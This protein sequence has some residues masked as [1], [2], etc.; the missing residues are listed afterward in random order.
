[1][2]SENPTVLS[3]QDLLAN[4]RT[5]TGINIIDRDALEPLEVLVDSL[6]TEAELHELGPKRMQEKLL[7]ILTNRLR[8]LRDFEAHPEIADEEIVEPIFFV[9][10][11]RTGSTK[12]QRML[13]SSEDFNWLPLWKTLNSASYTGKPNENVAPRIADSDHFARDFH[14]GSPDVAVTHEFGS[15]LAEEETF[16][17]IQSL[18]CSGFHAFAN[19]PAYQVWLASQDAER[20]YRYLRDALKYLQ[21]QGLADPS[22]RWLLKSPHHCGREDILSKVFPGASTVFTHRPPTQFLPS[23]CSLLAAHIASH[24]DNTT[25][26]GHAVVTGYAGDLERHVA[27]RKA[28]P[29][30]PVLDIHYKDATGN[31]RETIERFYKFVGLPLTSNALQRMLSWDGNNPIHKHGVHKYTLADFDLSEA[32]IIRQAPNYQAFYREAFGD[33]EGW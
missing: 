32:E 10:S 20:S 31:V 8:M 21:W 4:A 11:P 14:E 26:D 18:E 30:F 23:I 5:L 15:H 19:V 29:G 7:R 25:V 1:M 24:T 33:A 2:L 17:M 9:G 3:A 12:M 27:F 16:I 22:K 13:A 6:N 28:H